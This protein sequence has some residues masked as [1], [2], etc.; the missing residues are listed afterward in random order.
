VANN[1][2]RAIGDMRNVANGH[3]TAIRIAINATP[4][5]V[6]HCHAGACLKRGQTRSRKNAGT[7]SSR[8]NGSGTMCVMFW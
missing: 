6:A 7:T 4:P 1:R 3:S 5:K 2:L 8:G